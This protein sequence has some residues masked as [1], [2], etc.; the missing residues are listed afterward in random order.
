MSD[1]ALVYTGSGRSFSEH[2][3]VNHAA[4]EYVRG[5]AFTNTVESYFSVLNRGI[6]GVYRHVSEAHLKRYLIE[7]DFRHSNRIKLGVDDHMRADRALA[8]V[9]GKRLAYRTVSG[10]WSVEAGRR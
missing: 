7:F 4:K 10:K 5:E 2:Q 8:G 6:Y 9:K 1:E 3:T